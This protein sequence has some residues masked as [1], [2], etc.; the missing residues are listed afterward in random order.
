MLGVPFLATTRAFRLGY[1]PFQRRAISTDDSSIGVLTLSAD[2]FAVNIDGAEAI[3][4]AVYSYLAAAVTH[5][6]KALAAAA[7]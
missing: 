7:S 5:R 1:K 4:N 2:R 6:A 3:I